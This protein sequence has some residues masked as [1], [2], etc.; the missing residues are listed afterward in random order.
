MKSAF[1]ILVFTIGMIA[2]TQAQETISSNELSCACNTLQKLVSNASKSG[3]GFDVL[4]FKQAYEAMNAQYPLGNG[5]MNYFVQVGQS[6][7]GTDVAYSL[8]SVYPPP[9]LQSGGG[10]THKEIDMIHKIREN[11]ISEEYLNQ[12]K[13]YESLKKNVINPQLLNTNNQVELRSL[14]NGL[15]K[16]DWDGISTEQLNLLPA[17]EFQIEDFNRAMNALPRDY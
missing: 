14:S 10:F 8:S 15:G 2:F 11:N 1:S 17:R 3:R 4:I 6:I 5:C 9:R 13:L 7:D 16:L 12:F